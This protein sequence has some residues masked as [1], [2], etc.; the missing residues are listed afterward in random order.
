MTWRAREDD[1]R[2]RVG[3]RSGRDA[4][5]RAHPP[6][7]P[8]PP[9]HDHP[10]IMNALESLQLP[11]QPSLDLSIDRKPSAMGSVGRSGVPSGAVVSPPPIPPVEPPTSSTPPPHPTSAASTSAGSSAS[12]LAPPTRQMF[13]CQHVGCTKSYD[14]KSSVQAHVHDVHVAS[15]EAK[16]VLGSE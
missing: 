14:K 16:T 1:E 4:R 11:P 5:A 13:T 9:D 7:S 15:F 12:V 2:V 10:T 8:S 6:P 3:R